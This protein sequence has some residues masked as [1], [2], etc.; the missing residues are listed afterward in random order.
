MYVTH[1]QIIVVFLVG[2]GALHSR[3]GQIFGESG[4]EPSIKDM[5]G[6]LVEV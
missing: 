4:P 6:P 5:V 3:P 2:T 1:F